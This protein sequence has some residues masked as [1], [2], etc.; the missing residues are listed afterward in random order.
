MANVG[1][2]HCKIYFLPW[3]TDGRV[4]NPLSF[5]VGKAAREPGWAE[6]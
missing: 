2:L 3:V 6:L 5:A 4:G 1:K